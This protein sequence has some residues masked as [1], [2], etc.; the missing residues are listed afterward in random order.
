MPSL[1]EQLLQAGIVDKK[2]AKKIKQEKRKET[3]QQG[4]GQTV[5]E[6]KLAAQRAL[7]EKAERDREMNRLRNVEAEKKAIQAQII[8]L[9]E[10][11]RVAKGPGDTPYNFSD[12]KKIKKIYVS[13]LQHRQ[14]VKGQ[15]AVARLKDQYELVPVQ[16][17]EKIRQRDEAAILVLN[18]QSETEIAEDDPYADYQI[19][20]DLM[21]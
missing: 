8:Q 17:A 9:I 7:A 2:K 3:K 5:D 21:W 19:P 12:A 4:K 18:D 6:G 11:N 16:I 20:D 10:L 15:L 13:E 1:Q 14:L